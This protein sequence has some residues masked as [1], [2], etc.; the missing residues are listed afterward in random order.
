MHSSP[1]IKKIAETLT[2]I[3]ENGTT[4]IQYGYAEDLD[5][6]RGITCGR[7]GF[8]T[9]TGDAFLVVKQ[10]S[11][12]AP[13]HR[14][15]SFLPELERL[16][17]ADDPSDTSG[18]DGFIAAWKSA[19]RLKAFRGVQDHVTDLLYWV[20]SQRHADRLGLR[21]ALARAFI[22]DTIIQHG[23]SDDP[24]SLG[25]LL[26]QTRGAIGGTP[27]DGADEIKWLDEF[28]RVRRADLACCHEESS[29]TEWAGSVG[30]CDAFG[31]L[32]SDGNFALDTPFTVEW[33]GEKFL[34]T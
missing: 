7:S 32:V 17:T 12:I 25:S 23:D 18:L 4:R 16:N 28:I 2:S 15:S 1:N 20:P 27:A 9:G 26:E 14:L 30:R 34:V 22:F 21:T 3:F 8:C 5:D 6:G 33:E 11:K 31:K 24:D 29:R 19:A 10:F 13:D